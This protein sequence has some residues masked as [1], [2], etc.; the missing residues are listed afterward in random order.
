MV[1]M[2][3]I[4]HRT[5][6]ERPAVWVDSGAVILSLEGTH[7]NVAL[8]MLVQAMHGSPHACPTSKISIHML[9]LNGRS[10][11]TLGSRAYISWWSDINAHWRGSGQASSFHRLFI[12]EQRKLQ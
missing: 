10:Y 1:A 3:N 11:R 2:S 5:L 4:Y 7:R 12:A 8:A 6:L 9:A